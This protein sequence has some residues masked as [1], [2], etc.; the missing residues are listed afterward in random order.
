MDTIIGKFK[1]LIYDDEL[2][3]GLKR[4]L[5]TEVR[6][7]DEGGIR[8]LVIPPIELV[9]TEQ[10]EAL[11]T[12]SYHAISRTVFDGWEKKED[13][14][15]E[16]GEGKITDKEFYQVLLEKFKVGV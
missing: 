15:D 2:E 4:M 16:G 14:T 13:E 5:N 7:S 8:F 6:W 9:N 10:I 11:D 12:S 3:R 1:L